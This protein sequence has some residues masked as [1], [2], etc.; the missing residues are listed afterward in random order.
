MPDLQTL[1]W[2]HL[3]AAQQAPNGRSAER[4][5]HDG[6]LRQTVIALAAGQELGEHNAP[7]AATLQ[8]LH[9]LV[10]VTSSSVTT[11][12]RCRPAPCTRSRTSATAS[13]PRRTRCSS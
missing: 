5:V 8:V 10:R 3:E 2:R 4:V 11:T 1:T 6:E 12:S 13:R 9:G 7:H